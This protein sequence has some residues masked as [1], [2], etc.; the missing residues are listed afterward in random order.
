MPCLS[1]SA[2]YLGQSTLSEELALEIWWQIF[3]ICWNEFP[4]SEAHAATDASEVEFVFHR[5]FKTVMYWGT[6]R[7]FHS[8]RNSGVAV[9]CRFD[10]HCQGH[11]WCNEAA[12]L[13]HCQ[14]IKCIA[15]GTALQVDMQETVLP[16]FASLRCSCAFGVCFM[17][18][19]SRSWYRGRRCTCACPNELIPDFKLAH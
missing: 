16:T 8:L 7:S 17:S 11:L 1:C 10:H 4:T 12:R 3:Y 9:R 5:T 18:S 15:Q 6:C 13:G 2:Q 19:S 14:P